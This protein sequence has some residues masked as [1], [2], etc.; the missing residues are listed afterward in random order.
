MVLVLLSDAFSI[1]LYILECKSC[2]YVHMYSIYNYIL[3]RALAIIIDQNQA[4][5]VITDVITVTGS[6]GYSPIKFSSYLR[7]SVYT[8]AG[9]SW[10]LY[11]GVYI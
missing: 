11:Y 4:V 6:L 2:H 8:V 5:D 7:L 10:G 3:S 1:I 9:G